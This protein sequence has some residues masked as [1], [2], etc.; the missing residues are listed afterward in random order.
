[1]TAIFTHTHTFTKCD[2]TTA[3]CEVI[4]EPMMIKNLFGD[5]LT[6]YTM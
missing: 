1:M 2:H 4:C 5:H 6:L 3:S